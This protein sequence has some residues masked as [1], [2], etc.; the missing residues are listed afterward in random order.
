MKGKSSQNPRFC[1]S[2]TDLSFSPLMEVHGSVPTPD[3][4][5]SLSVANFLVDPAFSFRT[6]GALMLRE[7]DLSVTAQGSSWMQGAGFRL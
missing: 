4:E 7:N 6:G 5:V 3:L 2:P 1:P